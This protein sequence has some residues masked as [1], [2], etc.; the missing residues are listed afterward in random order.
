MEKHVKKITMFESMIRKIIKE[1]EFGHDS[2]GAAQNEFW[3]Q[4]LV[5]CKQASIPLGDEFVKQKLLEAAKQF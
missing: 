5:L 4:L 1:E 3:K 2:I